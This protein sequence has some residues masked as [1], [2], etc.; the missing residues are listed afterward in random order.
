M[1]NNDVIR[2]IRYTFNFNDSKMIE[3]FGL[4]GL[5]VTRAQISNWLK[6]DDDSD[7]QEL[8]DLELAIFLNGFIVEK[9]GKREEALPEPEKVL[10]NNI[11]LIKIKIALALK[12]DDIL[13][14]LEL[15]KLRVS[16]HELSAFFRNPKQ[17]QYRLCKDQI[18]RNF[19]YGLQIKYHDKKK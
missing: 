14:I 6:K 9:R 16:K 10:N 7:F 11:I 8:S 18:L 3:L 12:N 19:L 4:G 1:D 17:N 5:K 15:A 13:A 2:R